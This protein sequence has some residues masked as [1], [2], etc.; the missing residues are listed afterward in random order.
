MT[1]GERM[2]KLR[3]ALKDLV[4]AKGCECVGIDIS[5]TAHASVLRI[6]IDTPAGV[7]H[8][9]CV[10]I[11]KRVTD[12]LDK[13]ESSGEGW[14][15]GR[16]LVEVSSP[17][18]ERPLLTPEHYRRFAGRQANVILTSGKKVR[19]LIVSC[20]DSSVS[21]EVEGSAGPETVRVSF[22]DI[23]R[24]NLLFTEGRGT[25]KGGGGTARK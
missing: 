20:D 1:D 2:K 11:S 25:K 15:P 18:L 16:Y 7:R 13:C 10:E 14:F 23:R 24:G 19:G 17:G 8:A 3:G 5:L 6:Y 12:Y 9:E 4:E 21:F 22:E